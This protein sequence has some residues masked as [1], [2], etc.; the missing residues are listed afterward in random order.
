M[1]IDRHQTEKEQRLALELGASLELIKHYESIIA[2][3]QKDHQK[4]SH[5]L[6]N[7]LQ[8]LSMTLES[9]QDTAPPEIQS[10]IERMRLSSDAMT[11]ILINLRKL[12][13]STQP[14]KNTLIV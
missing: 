4:I 1:I 7:P 5:D 10:S 2:T 9:L 12:R 13:A 11:A 3:L 14:S 8:I 6:S